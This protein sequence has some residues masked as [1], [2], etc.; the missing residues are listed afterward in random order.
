MYIFY[1]QNCDKVHLSLRSSPRPQ[2]FSLGLFQQVFTVLLASLSPPASL[3]SHTACPLKY[4]RDHVPC[5][6]S[7]AASLCL[8]KKNLTSLTQTDREKNVMEEI[9]VD[10][11]IALDLLDNK[12]TRTFLESLVRTW[13]SPGADVVRI[14]GK[15][16]P[17][18]RENERE[19]F[20][21]CCRKIV[22]S[23]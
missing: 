1:F 13:L 12:D 11:L 7:F 4:T 22:S 9:P 19:R 5:L 21:R 20:C 6:K 17:E 18:F 14:Y 15:R 10:G 23:P 16:R 8:L 2:L 3:R